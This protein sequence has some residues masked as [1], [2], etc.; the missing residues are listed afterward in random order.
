VR[1]P[2]RSRIAR[3]QPWDSF[4]RALR[5]SGVAE[6]LQGPLL[7][8]TM[9]R[10]LLTIALLLGT[11]PFRLSAQRIAPPAADTLI[12]LVGATLID[13]NGGSPLRDAVVVVRGPRI[14]AV[15]PRGSTPVPP[16][17]RVVDA[18]GKYLLPGFV[19]TNVHLSIYSNLENFA[20]YEDRFTEVA[21]EAAQMHL[22]AGVTTVRDSYGMLDPLLAARDA[23]ARGAVPGPR[24]YVA[25]NIVGWGGPFSLS[26]TG[27]PA[28]NLSLFQEQMNDA[29]T[30]GS[31]EDLVHL[32]PDSLR[33]A[34]D[35]YLDRG[36]DFL[37][38]GGTS[39]FGNPV[40]IGF[41]EAAQKAIVDA[42]HARGKVA[43]THSTTP[44]GLG[45]SVLAGIDL[46]QH[47]ESHDVPMSPALV[48]LLV[49]RKVVCAIL[50]NT[51]TGKP[52]S[53][54]RK[55]RA[56]E[57][58]ARRARADSARARPGARRARTTAELKRDLGNLGLEIRRRNAEQL[59][60]GGCIVAVST[61][62]YLGLAPEFRRDPKPDWQEPGT[63]TLAAIEGL[64][65]LGM[66]PLQ[67]LTAATRNGAIA[68]KALAEYGTIEPGKFA[69]LLLLAGDPL[70]DI[71]NIRR[72]D[73]VMRGGSIVDHAALPNRRIWWR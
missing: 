35:R 24:V 40:F 39:H 21:I 23:I 66:T 6:G 4:E 64:V 19:D 38:Y 10:R 14:A 2:A 9:L 11:A 65:E 68:S 67:A 49:D 15:G 7:T 54:Y 36:V 3:K 25:G 56:R 47:P 5:A 60:R 59:I 71:G 43:E 58:S 12:A 1:T 53:D 62:N 17:A 48:N 20:R 41:S 29:I 70:A 73:L 22:K 45:I 57:D 8:L 30:R 16:G 26:F 18:A 32:E 13:G 52:W 72:L 61:D 28:E 50:S 55:Q 27:R 46:V 69:D 44:E 63:G 33:A 42:V 51:I 37:K 34:I 31:G